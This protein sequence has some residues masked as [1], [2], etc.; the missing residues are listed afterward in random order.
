MENFIT[1]CESVS[2]INFISTSCSFNLDI[3]KLIF[4]I[5]LNHNTT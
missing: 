4:M 2:A 5:I 1:D 3:E